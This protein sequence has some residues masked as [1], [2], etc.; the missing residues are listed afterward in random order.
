MRDLLEIPQILIALAIGAIL[1]LLMPPSGPL[2]SRAG[3]CLAVLYLLLLGLSIFGF[4]Y[5]AMVIVRSL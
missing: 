1:L 4:G 2:G 5:L 3:K